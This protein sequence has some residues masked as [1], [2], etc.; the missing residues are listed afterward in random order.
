ME[1]DNL[2]DEF[3]NYLGPQLSINV[4]LHNFPG[5]RVHL[6]FLRVGRRGSETAVRTQDRPERRQ[7]VF[8]RNGGSLSRGGDSG[9]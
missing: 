6:A 1:E 9:Q 3:G 4:F 2:Y 7:K 5:R 8:P